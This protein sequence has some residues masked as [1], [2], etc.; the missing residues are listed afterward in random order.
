MEI[1]EFIYSLIY[2]NGRY[3]YKMMPAVFTAIKQ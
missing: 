2:P 3:H 1:Y